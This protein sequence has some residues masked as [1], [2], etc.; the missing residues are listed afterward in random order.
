MDGCSN[1]NKYCIFSLFLKYV[2]ICF[3]E[4][5]AYMKGII[6][7]TNALCSLCAPLPLLVATSFDMS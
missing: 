7:L 2:S 1:E 4:T 3:K 5:T 6:A